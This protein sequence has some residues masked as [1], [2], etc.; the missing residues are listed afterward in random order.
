MTIPA[1]KLAAYRESLRR[2]LS[3]RLTETE[4]FELNKAHV[5]AKHLAQTLVKKHGA[6]RVWLF[7][8]I[9]RRQPLRTDSDVDLAVER[10]PPETFYKL[11][12][13]LQTESGRIVDLVRL[14]SMRPSVKQIILSEGTILADDSN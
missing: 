10:M 14:E 2:R 3:R 7:G 9:G 5:E 12:G 6:K 1:E 8:S 4:K 11:V 13:D